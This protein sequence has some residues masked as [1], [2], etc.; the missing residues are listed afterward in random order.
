MSSYI[1]GVDTGV[2]GGIAILSPSQYIYELLPTSRDPLKDTEKIKPYLVTPHKVHV[3]IEHLWFRGGK[4]YVNPKSEWVLAEN[5]GYW[6][7]FFTGAGCKISLV[8]AK[9]W[10]KQY[11]ISPLSDYSKRKSLLNKYAKEIYNKVPT[12]NKNT[13]GKITLKTCDAFLI[14]LHGCKK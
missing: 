8:L 10:Q 2:N 5:Y 9:E 13:K 14:A 4:E 6:L 12:K 1:I 7:G 11:K 3:F